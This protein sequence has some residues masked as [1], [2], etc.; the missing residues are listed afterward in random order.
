MSSS[1]CESKTIGGRS[2]YKNHQIGD[3]VEGYFNPDGNLNIRLQ[4]DGREYSITMDADQSRYIA[5]RLL[6][7]TRARGLM[8]LESTTTEVTG[9][10]CEEDATNFR[11]YFT[12]EQGG[13]NTVLAST[14][15]EAKN[16]A[17]LI[18]YKLTPNLDSFRTINSGEYS[19]IIR[20]KSQD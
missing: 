16:K 18:G 15:E 1:R 17:G 20:M 11:W 19:E 12:W 5:K 2:Q 9:K 3:E 14:R 10:D 4:I 6:I 8:I 13:W 7:D